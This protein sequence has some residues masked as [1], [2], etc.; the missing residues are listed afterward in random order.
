MPLSG[1]EVFFLDA[2]SWKNVAKL[3][4]ASVTPG[5]PLFPR[6]PARGCHSYREGPAS[7]GLVPV[8]PE[9]GFGGVGGSFEQVLFSHWM[10]VFLKQPLTFTPHWRQSLSSEQLK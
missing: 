2:I 10:D 7:P 6:R 8:T 1:K 3:N 5:S 9:R 4:G